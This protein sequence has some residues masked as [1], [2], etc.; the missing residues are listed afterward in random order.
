MTRFNRSLFM[1]ALLASS[2]CATTAVDNR[3]SNL[4]ADETTG[5][6]STPAPVIDNSKAGLIYNLLVAEI[7]GGRNMPTTAATYYIAAAEQN[8]DIELAQRATQVALYARDYELAERGAKIWVSLEPDRI[9][10]RQVLSAV[11]VHQGDRA[12]AREHI[13]ALLDLRGLK[14]S[15][16]YLALAKFFATQEDQKAM[17]TVLEE[18]AAAR[19]SDSEAQYAAAVMAVRFNDYV[20]ALRYTSAAIDLRPDWGE[21][22]MVHAQVLAL[23]E[24]PDAGVNLLRNYTDEHPQH[25]QA[26]YSLARML[27]DANQ[28][29]AAREEFGRI[30]QSDPENAEAL[31]AL[32]LLNMQLGDFDVAK[33]HLLALEKKGFQENRVHFYLGKIAERQNDPGEAIRWYST[34][35]DKEYRVDATARMAYLLAKQ[36]KLEQALALLEQTSTERDSEKIHLAVVNSDILIHGQRYDQAIAVATAALEKFPDDVDLLF[37]RSSAFERSRNY[38][39]MEADIR[40]ILAIHPDNAHALNALGYSLADRNLRLNEAH[41]L[42]TQALALEPDNAYILDSMGWVEYRL[43]NYQKAL[44]YLRKALAAM[45]DGEVYA[46][47]AR[48][49]IATG[50]RQEAKELLHKGL[51]ALPDNADISKALN[52]LNTLTIK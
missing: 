14:S 41:E 45:P 43:G 47:L 50:A 36:G 27:I 10:P 31:F 2:G 46:H 34:I 18:I 49:L 16:E 28:P 42:L 35:A 51:A 11:Y 48:V 32:G 20:K 7:A 8:P 17:L 5:P 33:T 23:N 15:K 40:A 6:A 19:P 9:E 25:E 52:H 21:A 39:A 4:G 30:H 44:P 12:A 29:S 1:V 3:Q 37:S 22:V 13:L 26:R 24:Q 38:D